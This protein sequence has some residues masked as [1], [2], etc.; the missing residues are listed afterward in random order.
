MSNRCGFGRSLLYWLLLKT[1]EVNLNW[2]DSGPRQCPRPPHCPPTLPCCNQTPNW[3][4]LGQTPQV[5]IQP[6]T[7][8]FQKK[9]ETELYWNFIFYVLCWGFSYW[10]RANRTWKMLSCFS[11]CASLAFQSI[12]MS[13]LCVYCPVLVWGG[14]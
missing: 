4:Q 9:S 2:G 14:E 8:N 1:G 13:C 12:G 10:K 7:S 3:H 11:Q 5:T 6:N